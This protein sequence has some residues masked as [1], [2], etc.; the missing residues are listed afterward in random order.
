MK[1][2]E[3]RESLFIALVLLIILLPVRIF[4]YENVSQHWLGSLGVV[5]IVT[6]GLLFLA[7]K[8]KLGFFGRMLKKHLFKIHRGKRK[9]FVYTNI[10]FF[11]IVFGTFAYTIEAG[12]T[13]YLE[14]KQEAEALLPNTKIEMEDLAKTVQDS[15]TTPEDFIKAFGLLFLMIVYRFDAFAALMAIANDSTNGYMQH[16]SIVFFVEQLEMIGILIYTRMKI[17]ATEIESL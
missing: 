6:L 3:I 12:N 7:Q 15:E 17:K 4:F 8:N 13:E 16:F 14:L 2:Q 11:T 5:S 10:V 9:Y 1:F